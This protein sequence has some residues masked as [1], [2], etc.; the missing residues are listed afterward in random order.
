MFSLKQ[1]TIKEWKISKRKER[2]I[3]PVFKSN[4]QKFQN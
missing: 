1:K 4:P 2:S 3:D